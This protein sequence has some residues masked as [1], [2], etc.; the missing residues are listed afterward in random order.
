M[1]TEQQEIKLLKKTVKAL[2]KMVY[3]QRV[4]ISK[5]SQWVFTNLDE[6]K[7]FYKINDLTKII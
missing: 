7:K 1:M 3:Q 5:M 4:G 6:A 2:A